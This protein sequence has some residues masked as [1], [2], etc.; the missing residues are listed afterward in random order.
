MEKQRIER[1]DLELAWQWI[2]REFPFDGYIREGRKSGY[3]DMVTRIAKWSG[4]EV[5][6]LD[7]GAGP[8]DKTAMFSKAGMK[9]TAFDTLQDA[10]HKLEGN[11]DKIL[12]FAADAGIEYCLPT[13]DIPF[14]FLLE[15]YDVLM[16]HDVLEHLH[17]SPRVLLN[18]ILP[19]LKPGGLVAITVPNA[20]NLRKRIHLLFGKTNYN[21]FE[22]FYWYPGMWHGHIR[23]YVRNDLKLLNDFLGL[24]LLELGT[25]N[26]QLDVLPRSTRKAYTVFASLFPGIRDS[27]MLVSR[28]PENWEPLFQPNLS[29]F[30]EALGSQYFDY[31]GA[32]FD[33]EE[34]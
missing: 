7:F 24:E 9:V 26:L 31:S 16:S 15:Q 13:E 25:Y 8:C 3:F 28:K 32:Q 33:W 2:N 34:S 5:S 18:K 4:R 29:Q 20:A 14:P 10:W 21:R 1:Q 19:C 30:Q 27:W 11:R 23:E 6:V 12:Q 22:Y 17:S